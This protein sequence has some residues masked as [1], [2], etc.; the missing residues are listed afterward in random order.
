MRFTIKKIPFILFSI[1]LGLIVPNVSSASWVDNLANWVGTRLLFLIFKITTSIA[2][3][4]V[5]LSGKL[6]NWVLSPGFISLSYTNPADNPIIKTGLD[7]TQGFVNMLLVLVL[8]YIAIATILQLANYDTKKLL[9]TF[10]VVALL[11]N[12]APVICGL[13]VDASNIIMNFFVQDLQADAFGKMMATKVENITSGFDQ[14]MDYSA[15]WSYVAQIAVMTPFLLALTFVLLIFTL[16]FILRYLAIWLLVILSPLAFVCY[17]LPVTK[18]YFDQW[19]EQF[20]NWSFIGVTCG[21]FLYLGLLLVTKM[22]TANIISTPTTGGGGAFDAI[23]PY[24]VSLVFLG[25]GIVFGLQTSAKG[26]STAINIAK[27]KGRAGGKW[28]AKKG[29]G[30]TK[31]GARKTRS[32]AQSLR[33]KSLETKTGKKVQEWGRRQLAVKQWGGETAGIKGGALRAVSAL[34]P[35]RYARRALGR[36]V[37]GAQPEERQAKVKKVEESVKNIE[38]TPNLVKEY[39]DA[40]TTTRR[41]GVL[42]QIIEKG[43]LK[44]AT[45]TKKFGSSAITSD[46]INSM[47]KTAKRWGTDKS[48]NKAFPH[49]AAKHVTQD[50]FE[51]AREKDKTI[52][53]NE[54][55]IINKMKPADYKNV[56]EEAIKGETEESKKVI[57]AILARSMGNHISQLIEQHGQIA[58]K[59]LEERIDAGSPV[60]SRLKKY[61]NTQ[62]GKGLI[63]PK[64]SPE[65]WKDVKTKTE[66]EVEAIRRIGEKSRKEQEAKRERERK[67]AKKYPD[68]GKGGKRKKYPDTGKGGE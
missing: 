38:E 29:W 34:N 32:V 25:I 27:T 59:A 65:D 42:N 30:A 46:E 60:N 16:I 13:I 21:F 55:V 54:D 26:A 10:I 9:V 47:M 5:E 19:W 20:L 3:W 36:A 18:K 43:K 17:I 2:I 22:P 67:L 66:E 4:F 7:I 23:L 58:A 56:S 39:Q 11:V 40:I 49:I 53:T 24:F 61:L 1:S 45:D 64:K 6:L 52:K 12:F 62:A 15:A 8:V 14:A 48:I 33:A 50:E 35:G 44:D 31:W 28:G 51:K 41:I 37:G 63:S 68:T 57:D